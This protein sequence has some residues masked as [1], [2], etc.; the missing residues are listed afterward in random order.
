MDVEQYETLLQMTST[1]NGILNYGITTADV[2]RATFPSG[3]VTGAPKI[4]T[5]QIIDELEKCCRGIYTGSIGWWSADQSVFSVAIRT[6]FLD[7]KSGELEMGVGSG[8][9]YEADIEREYRECELKAKFLTEAR[10]KFKLIETLRWEHASG[11]ANLNLHLDRLEQSAQYFLFE[12]NR[13]DVQNLRIS[14]EHESQAALRLLLDES[15]A[16][17]LSFVN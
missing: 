2:L 17:R 7:H 4:R 8:I 11:Y 12:F 1:I 6:L 14:E 3:S 9:L 10:P 15:G 13:D 5:M 16:W